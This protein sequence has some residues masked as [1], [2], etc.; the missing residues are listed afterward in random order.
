MPATD[1]GISPELVRRLHDGDDAALEQ[2]FHTRVESVRAHA[3]RELDDPRSAARV[4]ER[5]FVALW[6]ERERLDSVGD[7]EAAL[8]DQLAQQIAREKSR[9]AAVHRFEE[10]EHVHLDSKDRAAPTEDVLWSHV[11]SAIH[12]PAPDAARAA[13]QM[14]DH[15]RHATAEHVGAIA[16]RSQWKGA[17]AL[18]VG[19]IILVAGLIWALDRASMPAQIEKA[20]AAGDVRTLNT[21]SGQRGAVDLRDGGRVQLGPRSTLTIP[22]AYG[23]DLRAV[24]VEGSAQVTA[25]DD[26]RPI[27]IRIAGSPLAIIGTNVRVSAYP[28]TTEV[29]V[30]AVKDAEVRLPSETRRLAAGSTVAISAT[31]EV[32]TPA[33]VEVEEMLGWMDGQ[34]VVNDRPL[35][36][37]LDAMRLAYGSDITV[38][39]PSLLDRRVSVRAPLESSRDAIVALEA[40]GRLAFGYLDKQMVLRDSADPAVPRPRRR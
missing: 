18:A 19:G 22:A 30:G 35:R 2:I 24:R 3:T 5:V 8:S 36:E 23:D 11:N 17:A 31:G 10:T 1:P 13:H 28:R 7:V 6:R 14:A 15:S 9:L 34:F 16:G 39:D 20:L 38:T 32:R 21:N 40:S 12:A 37:A 27:D 26:A 25:A 4:T 33:P 29:F